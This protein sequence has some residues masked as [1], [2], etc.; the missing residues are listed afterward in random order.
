[1]RTQAL[2]AV[3]VVAALTI[4]SA[5]LADVA[6]TISESYPAAGVQRLSASVGVGTLRVVAGTG[7]SVRVTMTAHC[8]RWGH[9]CEK[10]AARLRLES[11]TGGSIMRFRVEGF[12][13][14]GASGLGVR[15]TLE[16]PERVR[17]DLNLGVGELSVHDVRGDVVANVGVGTAEVRTRQQGVGSVRVNVGVG[18]ATLID[19]H[20]R[21]RGS[22]FV[23]HTL[24]WTPGTGGSRVALHV[25]VGGA[26]VALR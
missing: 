20:G 9:G 8:R 14:F 26:E 18:N 2:A 11:D 23:G 25:G 1:M 6:R 15:L 4:A 13:K 12:P 19:D 17:L 10:R 7:D 22:G 21:R 16:V 24:N 5:A 3:A